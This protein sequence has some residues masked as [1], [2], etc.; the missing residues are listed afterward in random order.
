[1]VRRGLGSCD[2]SIKFRRNLRVGEVQIPQRFRVRCD[3]LLESLFGPRNP[4]LEKAPGRILASTS[5]SLGGSSL[6]GWDSFNPVSLLSGLK[7]I[8]ALYAVA[9]FV[10]SVL[11]GAALPSQRC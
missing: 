1:M 6:V 11:V 7:I 3:D 5:A 10:R 4:V 2:E 8:A 9:A